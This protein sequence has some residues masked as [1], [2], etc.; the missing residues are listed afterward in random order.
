VQ[1]VHIALYHVLC[2]CIEERLS[3]ESPR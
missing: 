3:G 2:G 1:Q